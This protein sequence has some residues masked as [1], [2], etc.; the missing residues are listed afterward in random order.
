MRLSPGDDEWSAPSPR[1]S[2][3]FSNLSIGEYRFEVRAINPAGMTSEPAA[4]SFRIL[5]PWYRSREA[6]IG[7][8][9][10]LGLTALAT[11]RFRERSIRLKNQAL[12]NLVKIRTEELL[13]ANTAK[14]EFLAGISHEIRN[15][16][17]GVVGIAESIKTE[18]M[19]PDSQRKLGLLRQC[20]GHLSGLLEDILDYSRMQS[21]AIELEI[22]SFDLRALLNSI[23]AITAIESER[24][25]IPVVVTISPGVAPHLHGDE[26]RIRQI[27]LNFV[28]NALKY[29]GQGLVRIT[30]RRK[31][32]GA[33]C[34]EVIFAVAD[35]GPGIPMAEQQ[36]LFH[37]F[38]RGTAAQERH[39]R[40][41]GL[42][43]ALSKG[44]ALSMGG[45]I[46]LESK[47]GHGSTFYFSGP[48]APTNSPIPE[49]LSVRPAELGPG[50]P[51]LV[52]DDEEY[53]CIAMTSMLE[54]MGFSV[55]STT[56]GRTALALAQS[57][58][59]DVVFLDYNMPGMSGSEICR[60]IRQP[61]N[62][63]TRAFIIATTA[64]NSPEIRAECVAAG[65]NSFLAKPV[66][67]EQSASPDFALI[68]GRPP[69][70][71]TT[72]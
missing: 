35:N 16:M 46:W 11:F 48:F 36:R 66:T 10:I 41:T 39:V 64:F 65:M 1:R 12:E 7:Y 63:S 2:F 15:P 21:G 37:R 4:I 42:G 13:K 45:H 22:I 59:F 55:Q 53:N 71:S 49:E 40:G 5:P 50:K 26:R 18:A 44:L 31:T 20:A 67:A 23:T 17:N 57:Q 61:P 19:D 28:G 14:D 25:G 38:E 62:L 29:S 56:N 68:L 54:T 27:L 30:V 72:D 32:S 8:I 6:F 9:I 58:S 33:D 51:A 43:L 60:A 52:V 47:P 34:R 3:E 24:C 70:K 69:S